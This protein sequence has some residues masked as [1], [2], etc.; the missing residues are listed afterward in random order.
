MSNLETRLA[1]LEAVQQTPRREYT[2][3]ERAVRC[4]YLLERGGP[5]ADKLREILDNVDALQGGDHAKP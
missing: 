2:D 4:A 5:G 3:T 1:K